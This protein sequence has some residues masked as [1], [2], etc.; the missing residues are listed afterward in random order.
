M[1][2]IISI[3]LV[4][5]LSSCGYETPNNMNVMIIT[6]IGTSDY[7]KGLCY[8]VGK[9]STTSGISEVFAES[10][11]CFYDNCGKF[12]VGDTIKISKR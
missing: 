10:R 11:F 7:G 6:E 4:V 1:K 2:I 12:N 8:Y 9:G 5:M 3:F